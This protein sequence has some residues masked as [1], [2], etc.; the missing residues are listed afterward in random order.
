MVIR[1][2]GAGE[3]LG[4]SQDLPAPTA[5][6]PVGPAAV[7]QRLQPEADRVICLR[8]P[9]DFWAVGSHYQHF[10]QV[11]DSEVIEALSAES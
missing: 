10:N 2:K 8:A 9:I 7:V 4:F 11:S 1:N 6:T 3:K 5:R